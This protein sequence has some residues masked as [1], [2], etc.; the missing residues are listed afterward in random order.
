MYSSSN[1]KGFII[2]Y[3][4]HQFVIETLQ[5]LGACIAFKHLMI[6]WS[7]LFLKILFPLVNSVAL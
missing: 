2:L 4:E 1:N 6:S 5:E 7:Y 3:K